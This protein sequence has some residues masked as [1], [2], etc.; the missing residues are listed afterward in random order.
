MKASP[1]CFAE[2]L[3]VSVLSGS[4][5][6]A[7]FI[8]HDLWITHHVLPLSSYL[9]AFAS[10]FTGGLVLFPVFRWIRRPRS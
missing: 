5:E 7:G 3:A 2:V 8:G 1:L 6:A 9:L 10:G 4:I